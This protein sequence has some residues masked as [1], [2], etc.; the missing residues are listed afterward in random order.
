[1]LEAQN[2]DNTDR[3][4]VHVDPEIELI[5]TGDMEADVAANTVVFTRHLERIIRRYPEQW[6]WLG[7]KRA[8]SG[9]RK[10]T[11]PAQDIEESNA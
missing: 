9:P 1:M 4:T 11:L 2:R 6:N 5:E 3:L 10:N 7:F 8:D